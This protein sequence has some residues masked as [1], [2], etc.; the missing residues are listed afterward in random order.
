MTS[1]SIEKLY[2]YL[3]Q[4]MGPSGWWPGDSK[5]EII[6]GAILV[7]NTN[8][9]N[10]DKVL[11]QLKLATGFD[12]QRILRLESSQLEQLIYSAGFYKNKALAIQAVLNWF[13]E[14]QWNYS[15][16][17]EK[18]G[19][20]LRI[21]L[22]KLRGIGQETAD[23]FLVYIF[24]QVAFISNA[25]ARKLFSYIDQKD[26]KSYQQ[27][28]AVV[29]MPESFTYLQAQDLHGLIDEFGKNYLKDPVRMERIA[30]EVKK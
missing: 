13:Q 20:D 26:Y 7:Q 24:D 29:Q 3:L 12:P 9:S 28:H 17:V 22:L 8:W 1:V 18:Y 23:V 25:Y 11:T 2:T 10:V 14:H 15:H 27:L 30:G 19:S 6:L 16:I 21:E 4:E 5:L